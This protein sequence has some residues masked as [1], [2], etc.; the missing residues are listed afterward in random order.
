MKSIWAKNQDFTAK[1]FDGREGFTKF[2]EGTFLNDALD[3]MSFDDI[4]YYGDG[5]I[6]TRFTS[7]SHHDT[8]S[9][10]HDFSHCMDFVKRD[11]FHRLTVRDFG[12]MNF[13]EVSI[14]NFDTEARVFA[15]QIALA[16]RLPF[17]EFDVNQSIKYNAWLLAEYSSNSYQIPSRVKSSH[18]YKGKRYDP[19][20]HRLRD[21]ARCQ[22]VARKIGKEYVKLKDVEALAKR[23]IDVCRSINSQDRAA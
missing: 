14:R 10:L 1:V 16:E 9:F 21:D 17:E 15:Y 18:I 5:L 19:V 3:I 6:P 23:T 8:S 4:H 22:W 7:M 20:T 13:D 12:F 2:F 11:Q